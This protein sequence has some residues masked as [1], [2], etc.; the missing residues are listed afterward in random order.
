MRPV[1]QP[2]NLAWADWRARLEDHL[3]AYA[4][5]PL[6]LRAAHFFDRGG[7]LNGVTAL[8]TQLRLLPECDP[9]EEL[10]EL[11]DAVVERLDSPD[12]AFALMARFELAL[13]GVLGFGLNLRACALTGAARI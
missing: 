4:I 6:A 9:H 5:E 3:G 1:L 2:D 7:A 13:I 12:G 11:A 10:F 8:C